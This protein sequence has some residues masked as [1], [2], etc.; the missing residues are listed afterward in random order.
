MRRSLM[1][2]VLV[3]LSVAGCSYDHI[4]SPAGWEWSNVRFGMER[5]IGGLAIAPD[6]SIK[7]EG[8]ATQVNAALAQAAAD[9]AQASRRLAEAAARIP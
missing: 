6:G 9:A 7:I 1:L 8:A 3:L 5:Q 2:A 4:K